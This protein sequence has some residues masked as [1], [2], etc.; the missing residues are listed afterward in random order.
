ML[1]SAAD[2]FHPWIG[3]IRLNLK[4]FDKRVIR[5]AQQSWLQGVGAFCLPFLSLCLRPLCS[6]SQRL[7]LHPAVFQSSFVWIKTPAT[8]T[9]KGMDI[10]YLRCS[11]VAIWKCWDAFNL[12]FPALPK[13][14]KQQWCG[15]T[16]PGAKDPQAAQPRGW[17]DLCS[18]PGEF[19]TEHLSQCQ[20]NTQRSS[21]HWSEHQGKAGLSWWKSS[22]I[23]AWVVFGGWCFLTEL[24]VS[25]WIVSTPGILLLSVVSSEG[26]SA[27]SLGRTRVLDPKDKLRNQ[28]PV[29]K[30]WQRGQ[31]YNRSYVIG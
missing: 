17:R 6:N 11:L 7:L 16:V 8:V 12:A 23:P 27:C 9:G 29:A 1:G 10:R 15:N 28:N 14:H 26:G 13:W 21:T 24:G 30:G 20:L 19:S 31:F 22:Q 2:C 25:H 5:M 4:I 18:L 3:A